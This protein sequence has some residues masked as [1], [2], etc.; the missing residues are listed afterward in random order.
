MLS[1]LLSSIAACRRRSGGVLP[2]VAVGTY[3]GTGTADTQ[4]VS[5]PFEPDLVLLFESGGYVWWKNNACWHGRTQRL[6]ANESAYVIGALDG[7]VHDPLRGNGFSVTSSGNT[8]GATFHYLALRGISE[9]TSWIGNALDPR[10]VE[11]SSAAPVAA[12]VKR[13][14][15]SAGVFRW[16]GGA[17]AVRLDYQTG[18]GTYIRSLD[19]NGITV[20]GSNWSNEND[21]LNK[22][23]GCHAVALAA[24]PSLQLLTWTGDGTTSRLV[25]C[26][27]QPVAALVVDGVNNFTVDTTKHGIVTS[28]MAAGT[29]K[30]FDN[31]AVASG[32]VSG[33]EAGGLRLGTGY[34][35]AG[36]AYVALAFKASTPNDAAVVPVLSGRTKGVLLQPGS[37]HI[38]LANAPALS[39]ACSIEWYGRPRFRED[40]DG[41]LRPM[42]LLMLGQGDAGTFA[43]SAGEYNGGLYFFSSDPESLGWV[44]QVLRW[45][46]H[47]Y[48]APTKD[49]NSINYW[50]L[51]SGWTHQSGED[52]HCVLTHDGAGHWELFANGRKVK[53]YNVNLNQ[54]TYGNRPNGG[55]GTTKPAV[56]GGFRDDVGS[57]QGR[58]RGE[59]YRVAIWAGVRLSGAEARARWREAL[60]VGS[61]SG[62]SPTKAWDFMATGTSTDATQTNTSVIDRSTIPDRAME[63]PAIANVQTNDGATLA[64]YTPAVATHTM[65]VVC[66]SSE[67]AGNDQPVTGVTFGGVAL[68]KAVEQNTL[69][70]SNAQHSSVWY[71]ASPGTSAGAIAVAGG[72][73]V[74]IVALTLTAATGP[75][76]L[77]QT[78]TA[79]TGSSGTVTKTYTST[80]RFPTL[81]L[82][83]CSSGDVADLSTTALCRQKSGTLATVAQQTAAATARHEVFSQV[84]ESQMKGTLVVAN[85]TFRSSIALASFGVIQ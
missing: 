5:L 33:L 3:V 8:V 82:S 42:Y 30:H 14:S 71:L 63:V 2:G 6:S 57:I 83:T 58:Q 79:G 43:T 21:N 19:A 75:V 84:I 34:N 10:S 67:D 22:G 74:G 53:D 24:G 60:G 15:T 12:L 26:G 52:L 72:Q 55:A 31:T 13:D 73:S 27:F 9:D 11:W 85:F 25:S 66:V 80:S 35:V 62:P 7:A 56:I 17:S 81:W 77:Q 36:R 70:S 32:L 78:D 49:E 76:S 47:T 69:L 23:E 40:Y 28:T 48:Y 51:N 29:V 37:S 45:I 50:N 4:L 61:Y 68:T 20:D 18:A 41:T 44:G 65:L 46:Q 64:S 54:A 38:S 1:L 16:S 39:G 59:V